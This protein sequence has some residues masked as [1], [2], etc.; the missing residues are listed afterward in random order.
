M[1]PELKSLGL[2][3][4]TAA[5]SLILWGEAGAT[6]VAIAHTATAPKT[7]DGDSATV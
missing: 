5:K 1:L 3:Y 6:K 7:N 4:D 2:R